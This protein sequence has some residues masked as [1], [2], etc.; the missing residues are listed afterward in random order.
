MISVAH[1]CHTM[2]GLV[3]VSFRPCVTVRVLGRFHGNYTS[4]YDKQTQ[5]RGDT[6]RHTRNRNDPVC[7]ENNK[8]IPL[9]PYLPTRFT[10]KKGRQGRRKDQ[11]HGHTYVSCD[12][13][14]TA[15]IRGIPRVCRRGRWNSTV[16]PPTDLS[17]E[18]TSFLYDSAFSQRPLTNKLDKLLKGTNLSWAGSDGISVS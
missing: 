18:G 14:K 13:Q 10:P 11:K 1:L 8:S 3:I 6:A 16:C 12:V 5:T 2:K 9:L 7:S 17:V 15:S 4:P